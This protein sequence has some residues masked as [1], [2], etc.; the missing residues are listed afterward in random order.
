MCINIGTSLQFRRVCG[1]FHIEFMIMIWAGQ[2]I[3]VYRK[4]KMKWHDL[5]GENA[6]LCDAGI[7]ILFLFVMCSFS[8]WLVTQ[9]LGVC[10]LQHVL[11]SAEYVNQT[12]SRYSVLQHSGHLETHHVLF[13]C[14]CLFQEP[15][16]RSLLPLTCLQSQTTCLLLTLT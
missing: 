16:Q 2:N 15:T 8:C 13:Y 5:C 11:I 4:Q 7:L 14:C 10:H 9:S 12:R 1:L 3:P 6:E